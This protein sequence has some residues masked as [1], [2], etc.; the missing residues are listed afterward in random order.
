MCIYIYMCIYICVCVCIYIYIYIWFAVTPVKCAIWICF[1]RAKWTMTV[2]GIT[3]NYS[4]R[5]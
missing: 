4:V 1:K 5:P 2:Q 3:K